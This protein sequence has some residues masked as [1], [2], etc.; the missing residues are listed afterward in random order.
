M[1]TPKNNFSNKFSNAG[2]A[3]LQIG[4][5]DISP[6]TCKEQRDLR[7]PDLEVVISCDMRNGEFVRTRK[8]VRI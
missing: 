8:M 7:P 6:V 2:A 4:T 5:F 1:A 3:L